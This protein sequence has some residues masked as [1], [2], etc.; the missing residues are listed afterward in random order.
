MSAL[1]QKRTLMFCNSAHWV[2]VKNPKGPA[3][4]YARAGRGLGAIGERIRR[5]PV[6]LQ[7]TKNDQ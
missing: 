7:A 4:R 5:D 1:G 3:R 2:K 6:T